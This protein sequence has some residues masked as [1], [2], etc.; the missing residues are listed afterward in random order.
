MTGIIFLKG[1][2]YIYIYI[3]IERERERVGVAM[4]ALLEPPI[5]HDDN[6]KNFLVNW[7][8]HARSA[9]DFYLCIYG[10]R[11]AWS[12]QSI[13]VSARTCWMVRWI[14]NE[15][16]WLAGLWMYKN[17]P[18]TQQAI[19]LPASLISDQRM[20][21]LFHRQGCNHGNTKRVR[22]LLWEKWSMFAGTRSSTMLQ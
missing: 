13:T 22:Y 1:Y 8:K 6:E 9:V 10:D 2:I 3:Y 21:A 19:S 4:S 7:C 20:F 16:M 12:K 15:P 18:L 11:M 5:F 17:M 14:M